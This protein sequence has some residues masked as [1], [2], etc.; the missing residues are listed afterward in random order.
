M[1]E[2]LKRQLHKKNKGSTLIEMVVSFALLAIFVSTSVVIISNVTNLYYH[3]RGESYARQIGDIVV[4]KISS[5][6]SQAMYNKKN[7]ASNPT[8]YSEDYLNGDTSEKINGNSIELYDRTNTRIR[9]Y[10]SDGI[11]K[12]YYYPITD[13]TVSTGENDLE[14]VYWTFDKNIYN[15]Y[16]IEDLQFAPANSSMNESLANAYEVPDTDITEYNSNV[17]AVYMKIKSDKYGTFN[18]CRYVRLYNQPEGKDIECK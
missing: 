18:V 8:I 16:E 7:S 15:G 6:V 14:S 3:V 2:S 13:E 17:I 1:Y 9:I 11:L 5:E 10:S 4:N 12:I